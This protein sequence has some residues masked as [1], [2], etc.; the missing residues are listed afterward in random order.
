M[1]DVSLR[2]RYM[3]VSIMCHFEV[4]SSADLREHVQLT[5]MESRQMR[6]GRVLS[7]F[8]KKFAFVFVSIITRL[9]INF[10]KYK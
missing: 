3:T 7:S 9:N 8:L 2:K 5:W 1:Y 6:F 10:T 4:L